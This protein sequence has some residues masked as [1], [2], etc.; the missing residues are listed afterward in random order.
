MFLELMGAREMGVRVTALV[1]D[2]PGGLA[3]LSH[4]IAS[5]KG[6]FVSFGVFTGEDSSNRTVTFKVGGMDLEQV[7]KVIQPHVKEIL[8]IRA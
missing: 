3:E 2:K 5:E 7:K 8:D 4:A 1:T 6:N